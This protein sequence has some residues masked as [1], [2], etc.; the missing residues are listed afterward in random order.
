MLSFNWLLGELIGW[1]AAVRSNLPHT[2]VR[3]GWVM[4]GAI[5]GVN[6]AGLDVHAFLRVECCHVVLLISC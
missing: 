5:M 2:S 4:H 1:L 3:P 6:D